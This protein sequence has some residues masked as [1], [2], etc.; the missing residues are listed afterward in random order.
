MGLSDREYDRDSKGNII[1]KGNNTSGKYVD[2][3]DFIQTSY[4]QAVQERDSNLFTKI[5]NK[6]VR[7]LRL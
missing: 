4:E 5:K 3:E 2:V 7:L 1:Y 6:I